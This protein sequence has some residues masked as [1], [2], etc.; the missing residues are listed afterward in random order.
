MLSFFNSIKGRLI[1]AI[2]APMAGIG[3]SFI[4]SMQNDVIR[5]FGITLSNWCIIL[6]FAYGLCQA[7][8]ALLKLIKM[9]TEND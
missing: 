9:A 8:L 7:I 5:V 1:Q 4:I 6:S 3:G 2:G